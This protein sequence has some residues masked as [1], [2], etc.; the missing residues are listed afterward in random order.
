M[1]MFGWMRKSARHRGRASVAGSA[2]LA[3]D[4]LV[5]LLANEA[6]FGGD[7]DLLKILHDTLLAVISRH[8]A[9]QPDQV[10]LRMHRGATAGRI[11]IE[12]QLPA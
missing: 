3:R 4:R 1:T 2:T 8:A 10:R 5:V 9:V 7:P 11:A 6:A 12:I